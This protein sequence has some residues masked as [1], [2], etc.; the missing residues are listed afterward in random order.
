MPPDLE[1][2]RRI[3]DMYKKIKNASDKKLRMKE[4]V[5]FLKFLVEESGNKRLIL[6][7]EYKHKRVV[8]GIFGYSL[9][10]YTVLFKTRKGKL[11]N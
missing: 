2:Q 1:K 9:L 5:E 7:N 8:E 11:Y 10:Y 3:M 6:E 4:T